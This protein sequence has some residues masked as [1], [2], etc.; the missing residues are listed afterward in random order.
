VTSRREEKE[1]RRA[2][3]IA[4]EQAAAQ[5]EARRRR[6][7][8]AAGVVLAIAALAA[9]VYVVAAGGGGT[10]GKT[11]PSTSAATHKVPIPPPRTTDLQAAAKAA[12]CQLRTYR[13]GPNDR[14]HVTTK[15]RYRQ[16]PPVFGPHYPV[17]AH[18]GDY[19]GQ[20]APPTEQL[21]HALEHGRV[22]IWY[23][24]AIGDRRIGQLETLLYEP[25]NS[26]P[27]GYKMVL[28]E[29]PGMPFQVAATTW[30]QQLGCARFNDRTFD[31]LRSFRSTYV[32]KAPE[33]ML[34]PFPE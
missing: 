3:R 33:G 16:N 7:G 20:G 24:P 2:E 34:I 32:D 11:G 14:Q 29:R 28:V 31:A 25:F 15:V 17:P 8:I 1:R 30:G 6:L 26:K 19:A 12:G 22:I 13:P 9:V 18:D 4:A 10:G 21:V 27:V 5:A 23:S